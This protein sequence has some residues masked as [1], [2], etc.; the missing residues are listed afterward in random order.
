MRELVVLRTVSLFR[1][2]RQ[3]ENET[4]NKNVF[5]YNRFTFAYL[6]SFLKRGRAS[7][8]S[9]MIHICKGLKDPGDV[10][11]R[12]VHRSSNHGFNGFM[13]WVWKILGEA[14]ST[15]LHLV[16]STSSSIDRV[17]SFLVLSDDMLCISISKRDPILLN[18]LII[19]FLSQ[20]RLDSNTQLNPTE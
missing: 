5:H 20:V 14:L 18:S 11:F 15:R 3:A 9:A 10:S 6:C 16:G 7:I 12:P 17:W 2:D 1:G 4:N 19:R 8:V 13:V